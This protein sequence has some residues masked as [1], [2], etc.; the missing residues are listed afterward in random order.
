MLSLTVREAKEFATHYKNLEGGEVELIKLGH[1][2]KCNS[3]YVVHRDK[4]KLKKAIINYLKLEELQEEIS[5]SCQCTPDR[6]AKTI[7]EFKNP[8]DPAKVTEI[9]KIAL[10]CITDSIAMFAKCMCFYR[11]DEMDDI[12]ARMQET[13]DDISAEICAR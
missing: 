4:L 10:D 6:Q 3:P 1:C 2:E 12:F 8:F 13:A 9:R 5:S 7:E 11:T